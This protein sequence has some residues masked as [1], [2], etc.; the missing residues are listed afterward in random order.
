MS[1]LLLCEV[2]TPSH[3]YLCI[4][5]TWTYSTVIIVAWYLYL[6]TELFPFVLQTLLQQPNYSELEEQA[7]KASFTVTRVPAK[8]WFLKYWYDTSQLFEFKDN[9][10]NWG[11]MTENGCVDWSPAH[12][13]GNHNLTGNQNNGSCV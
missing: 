8:W 6:L 7:R 10:K 12:F 9:D 5:L 3:D 4:I 11:I 2:V 1:G 13:Y